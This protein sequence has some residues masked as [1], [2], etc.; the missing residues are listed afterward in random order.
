[1][2]VQD[3]VYEAMDRA[4]LSSY[5]DR[6]TPVVAA[7]REREAQ[8]AGALVEF[9]TSQGLSESAAWAAVTDAGMDTMRSVGN[10]DMSEDERAAL[11]ASMDELRRNMAEVVAMVERTTRR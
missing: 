2:G 4:G 10:G 3:T 6:A 5:R 7:L 11:L 1:M 8:I 9:A